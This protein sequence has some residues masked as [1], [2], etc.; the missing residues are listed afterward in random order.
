M[1][2]YP[3]DTRSETD[4]TT[5]YFIECGQWT[6]AEKRDNWA[7]RE[8]QSDIVASCNDMDTY[9]SDLSAEL[10]GTGIDVSS[11]IDAVNTA[12]NELCQA[13]FSDNGLLGYILLYLCSFFG[14]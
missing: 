3:N 2:S 14:G 7:L 12:N 9:T 5:I 8:T 10:S 4:N 1:H 11:D 13:I 6:V